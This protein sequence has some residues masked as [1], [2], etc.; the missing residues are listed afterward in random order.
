MSCLK[1]CYVCVCQR[2]EVRARA[3]CLAGMK[4]YCWRR[5]STVRYLASTSSFTGLSRHARCSLATC[6][7][8]RRAACEGP[9]V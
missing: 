9:R 2:G 7:H 3:L 1:I 6:M 8:P 4:R 5:V